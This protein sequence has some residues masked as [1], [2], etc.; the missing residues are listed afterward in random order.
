MSYQKVIQLPFAQDHN[1][2]PAFREVP[3]EIAK[4]LRDG[5][6]NMDDISIYNGPF[7]VL[8]NKDGSETVFY[9]YNHSQLTLPARTCGDFKNGLIY[10]IENA[11][12]FD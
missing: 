7:I 1:L 12:N 11:D 10:L 3:L 4:K 8:N 9:D 6:I 5:E 2:L